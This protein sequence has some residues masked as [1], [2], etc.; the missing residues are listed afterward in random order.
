[1]INQLSTLICGSGMNIS[2]MA[3]KSRGEVEY[4]M[5]DLD[6]QA[7]QELADKI[8]AVPDVYRVRIIK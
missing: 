8:A 2:E 4:T 6:T 5:F 1:M 7:T 3:S